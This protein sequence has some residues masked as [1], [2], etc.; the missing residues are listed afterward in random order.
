MVEILLI[1]GIGFSVLLSIGLFLYLTMKIIEF[2]EK[3]WSKNFAIYL[4]IAMVILFISLTFGN[5]IMN[6][7][8]SM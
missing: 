2:T 5:V 7:L 6:A 1:F 4:L 8:K 3:K